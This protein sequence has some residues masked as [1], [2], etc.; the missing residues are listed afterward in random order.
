M[1]LV[2]VL[3]L[4]THNTCAH[5][6]SHM[7]T[8]AYAQHVCSPMDEI[9]NEEEE[10]IHQLVCTLQSFVN[11][12]SKRWKREWLSDHAGQCNNMF[13]SFCCFFYFLFLPHWICVYRITCGDSL[14]CCSDA[15]S[16]GRVAEFRYFVVCCVGI[17][18]LLYV[19]FNKCNF[20]TL[21]ACC[22]G[23]WGCVCVWICVLCVCV[24]VCVCYVWVCVCVMCG[25]VC[26]LC[27]G[28]R[29][30]VLCGYVCVGVLCVG[31]CNLHEALGKGLIRG[32][33]N[34][35]CIHIF[36]Q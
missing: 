33:F 26:V 24:C 10:E 27:V 25:Y 4:H 8:H 1:G 35:F 3:L 18:L 15:A 28:M 19:Y 29:V 17:C 13:V 23:V 14:Q 20:S 11:E 36:G 22:V 5:T 30:C 2:S 9:L 12:A 7:H 6:H 34:E 31:M 16:Y 21:C 32:V